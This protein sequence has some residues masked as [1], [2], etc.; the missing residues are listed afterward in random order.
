MRH[1]RKPFRSPRRYRFRDRSRE[2]EN[3]QSLNSFMFLSG[4]PKGR[5]KGFRGMAEE[6]GSEDESFEWSGS[7][8]SSLHYLLSLLKLLR[9]GET[10]VCKRGKGRW[11]LSRRLVENPM[12]HGERSRLGGSSMVFNDGYSIR[13]FANFSIEPFFCLPL[14]RVLVCRILK[15][16][17][18]SPAC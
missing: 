8:S 16:Y 18:S 5:G 17:F 4:L 10:I 14:P 13:P 6:G 3:M 15:I 12:G 7:N 2:K 11:T 1:I 9:A